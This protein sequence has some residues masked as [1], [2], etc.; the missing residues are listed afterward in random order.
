MWYALS[1]YIIERMLKKHLLLPIDTNFAHSP[2]YMQNV[3]PFIREQ[4][5]KLSQPGEEA[6]R[7]AVC[8]MWGTAGILYNRAY[9]PDSVATSWECLWNRKYAGKILM[10]DSYRDA[11]GTAIIYVHAKELEEGTVTVE[12]L[13]N[14]YS[15]RADGVGGEISERV[16]TEYCRLGSGLRQGDDDEK[17]GLA[18]Y[19]VEW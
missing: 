4:I 16:E 15:P 12:E 17:Q 14:D 11:Y 2:N 9:I 18:E 13:M 8:Y 10:K 6:S 3:A 1:E 5:N 19:D 7:Y